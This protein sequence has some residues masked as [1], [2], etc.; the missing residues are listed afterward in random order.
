[1]RE[2]SPALL[3]TMISARSGE[4][5][6]EPQCATQLPGDAAGLVSLVQS[7]IAGKLHRVNAPNS[8]DPDALTLTLSG[9]TQCGNCV[10]QQAACSTQ[11]VNFQRVRFVLQNRA[12]EQVDAQDLELESNPLSQQADQIASRVLQ[13]A[14]L[15]AFAQEAAARRAQSE[16]ARS[17]RQA[18]AS[19][20]ERGAAK[21][22]PP[23]ARDPLAI[24]LE[25]MDGKSFPMLPSVGAG[26]LGQTWSVG[27]NQALLVDGSEVHVV[28]L[29]Q[30]SVTA[31]G[32]LVV[33]LNGASYEPLAGYENF[34]GGRG[35]TNSYEGAILS[36]DHKNALLLIR[37]TMLLPLPSE[38]YGVAMRPFLVSEGAARELPQKTPLEPSTVEGQ[39]IVVD[40]S[41][42]V[43]AVYSFDFQHSLFKPE[44]SRTCGE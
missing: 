13:S 42:R 3:H 20:V 7:S 39:R 32:M 19:Q 40:C 22:P 43:Q 1:M 15:D 29:T 44:H 18:R 24:A 31:V 33:R 8:S 34:S 21:P 14:R 9:K 5:T 6:G 2:P 16:A 30:P 25:A 10:P 27:W 41:L 11:P 35:I 26:P 4:W 36:P 38:E 28:G 23:P 37:E 17:Q 12:G